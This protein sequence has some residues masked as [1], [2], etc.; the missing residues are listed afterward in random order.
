V[1]WAIVAAALYPLTWLVSAGDMPTEVRST[2][3]LLWCACLLPTAHYV[4]SKRSRRRPFPFLPLVGIMYGAYFAL[5]AVAGQSNL[6]YIPFQI[7]VPYVF[8]DTD[9]ALP[10]RLALVGWLA[11]L[12]GYA[13]MATI[14]LPSPRRGRVWPARPLVPWLFRLAALGVLV[15]LAQD[16]VHLPAVLGGSL[17]FLTV[18][19]RFGLALLLVLRA[20]GFLNR[21]ERIWLWVLIAALTVLWATGGSIGKIF[22]LLILFVLAHSLGGGRVPAS[23]VVLG[24]I[25]ILAV[26]TIKGILPDYRRQTWF[27]QVRLNVVERAGLMF[28]LVRQRVEDRGVVGA[29]AAG[30]TA[31]ANRSATL[32]LFA[33]V[34]RRTPNDIPYMGGSTYLSLVGAFVP[35]VL[36]P[37]KPA[38][39]LGQVFGHRYQYLNDSDTSTSINLPFLIEFYMNFGESGVIVGMFLVGII[40][41]LLEHLLNRRGQDVVHTIVGMAILVPML[42]LESDFSLIFG[43]VALDLIAFWIVLRVLWQQMPR[44]ARS[45]P[46]TIRTPPESLSPGPTP[47]TN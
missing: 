2:G 6:N 12:A 41:T 30:L 9:Y 8:P 14:K 32:D 10:I 38:K 29:V 47:L 43:G 35:R 28:E 7:G 31:S 5:A 20:R 15:Q 4:F 23:A 17:F 13:L 44:E 46:R 1:E 27:G 19:S 40:Y 39:N 34:A 33:D 21:N 22:L 37:G 36:W 42:D 25:G 45:A 26:A 18:L 11:L 24:V 16:T 3:A